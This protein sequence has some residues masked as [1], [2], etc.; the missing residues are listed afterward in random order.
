MKSTCLLSL[1]LRTVTRMRVSHQRMTRYSAYPS[2]RPAAVH[3]RGVLLQPVRS[4]RWVLVARAV[5]G[6]LR[7]WGGGVGQSCAHLSRGGLDGMS[8]QPLAT[9]HRNYVIR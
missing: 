3:G 9:E 2:T 6:D 8:G 1:R 4:G 7:T 5:T